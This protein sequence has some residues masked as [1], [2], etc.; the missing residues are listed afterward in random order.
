TRQTKISFLN[1]LHLAKVSRTDIQLYSDGQG[2]SVKTVN[3]DSLQ[4]LEING[5]KLAINETYK[6]YSQKV[7]ATS[8]YEIKIPKDGLVLS[9]D[10]VIAISP[11]NLINPELK[12]VNQYLN[13][14]QIDYILADYQTPQQLGELKIATTELDLQGAYYEKGQY[15][16]LLSLPGF[17]SASGS[18][19]VKELKVEL[20]GKTFWQ[21][22]KELMQN[23]L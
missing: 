11:E 1:N 8:T 19:V 4:V 12:K 7:K 3:P 14:E 17:D 15:S 20:S 22:I 23:Y 13:L 18:V 6:Q 10:G 9:T 5:E 16:F 2:V 21:K